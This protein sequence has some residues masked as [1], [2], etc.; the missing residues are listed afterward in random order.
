MKVRLTTHQ[1]KFV[2]RKMKGGGYLTEDEVIREALRVY[3]L[4]EQEDQDSE[5]EAALRHSL[6]SP[7]KKYK[8]GRFAALANRNSRRAIAA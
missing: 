2:E 6:R 3:E 8:H 5:L 7:L 1:Q 4:I